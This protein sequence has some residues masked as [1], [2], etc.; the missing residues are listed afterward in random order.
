VEFI[1]GGGVYR[2]RWGRLYHAAR[3]P[4]TFSRF[5]AVVFSVLGA[6]PPVRAATEDTLTMRTRVLEGVDWAVEVRRGRRS[7]VR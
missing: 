4:V 7:W 1:G 3:V 2:G 5:G 6:M